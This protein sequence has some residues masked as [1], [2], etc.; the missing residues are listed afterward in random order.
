M[1]SDKAR[2]APTSPGVYIFRNSASTPIYI[3][4]AKNIR[5]RVANYFGTGLL[6]RTEQM[7]ANAASLE[8]IVT[9]NEAE[10]LLL[11]S[12]LIA[13]YQPKYNLD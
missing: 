5:N 13:Q 8:F 11:E 9:D 1:L 3:G 4:K 12:R 6:D 2:S 7:V 10:A